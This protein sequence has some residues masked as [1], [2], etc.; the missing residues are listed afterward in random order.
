MTWTSNFLTVF[1]MNV[2]AHAGEVTCV[3][4]PYTYS[5]STTQPFFWSPLLFS[6]VND[7]DM[8]PQIG[9][10][11]PTN[12]DLVQARASGMSQRQRAA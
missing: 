8:I 11:W 1:V 7:R 4:Y 6:Q 5:L 9:V 3:V 12:G 2:C 10:A